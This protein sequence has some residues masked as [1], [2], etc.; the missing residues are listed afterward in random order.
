MKVKNEGTCLL[1]KSGSFCFSEKG[2]YHFYQCFPDLFI[3]ERIQTAVRKIENY[4]IIFR[5]S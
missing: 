5:Q 4:D 2:M 3:I 1:L